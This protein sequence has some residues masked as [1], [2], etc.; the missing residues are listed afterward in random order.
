MGLA[1]DVVKHRGKQ[2]ASQVFESDKLRHSIYAACLSVRTPDGEAEEIAHNV[3][4]HVVLWLENKPVVTSQ[5]LR[6]MV[7][8]NLERY[9]PEAAYFYQHHRHIL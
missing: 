5:D 8:A 7:S 1:V 4:R 2:R 9:H 3:T 6:R